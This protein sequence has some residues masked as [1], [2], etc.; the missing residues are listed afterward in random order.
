MKQSRIQHFSTMAAAILRACCSG[1][2]CLL[3]AVLLLFPSGCIAAERD[4]NEPRIFRTGF[5]QRV[6]SNTDPRDAKAVLEVHSNEISR[7]LGLKFTAKVVMF[8]DMDSM[9][10]ALR[11]GELDLA[12][13]PSVDYLRIRNSV[14]L[15]PAFVGTGNYGPGVQYVMITRKDSGIRSFSDLKGRS[16]FLPSVDKYESSQIWLEILLMKE[17]KGWR[18]TFFSQVKEA[19]KISN[20]IMGVFFRQVDCAIVTRGTLDTSQQLNPQLGTQLNVLAE[21]P[22]LSD[23]VVCLVPGTS[24]N[25]RNNIYKAMLTLNESKSGKQI[26]TIFQTNGITPF[27]PEYLEGLERLLREHKRLKAKTVMRK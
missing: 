19:A 9:T 16:V 22:N 8:A 13:I 21:S 14:P 12:A 5:M 18:D 26:Y 24:D 15:L 3:S 23:S 2:L 7:L 4:D 20:A 6:F 11:R 17:G 1:A 10:D 25:F 27:K